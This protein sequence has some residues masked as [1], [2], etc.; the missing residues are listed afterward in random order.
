MKRLRALFAVLL[1]VIAVYANAAAWADP[2]PDRCAIAAI[3]MNEVIDFE[4]DRLSLDDEAPHAKQTSLP[5]ATLIASR[6]RAS[7]DG[8]APPPP[9]SPPD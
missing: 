4:D 7:P 9:H 5:R 1:T 2:A 8:L 6:D 3:D